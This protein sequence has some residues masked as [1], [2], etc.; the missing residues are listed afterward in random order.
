MSEVI[1]ATHLKWYCDPQVE[2]ES[3]PE[4]SL[5]YEVIAVPTVLYIKVRYTLIGSMS[6]CYI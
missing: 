6:V 4:I 3:L 5:K 2:A 1:N